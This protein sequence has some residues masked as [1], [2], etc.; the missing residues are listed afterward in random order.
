MYQIQYYKKKC[1]GCNACIEAAPERWRISKNDG[2]SIL[3]GGKENN[4]IYIINISDEEVVQ[5]KKAS[6]SCPTKIIKLK[7]LY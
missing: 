6:L 2:K 7:R 1:I 5:N 4:K 3:I